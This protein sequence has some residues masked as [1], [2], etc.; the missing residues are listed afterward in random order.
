MPR[1]K[2]TEKRIKELPLPTDKDKIEYWDTEVT[3]L[4]VVA[5]KSGKKRYAFAYRFQSLQQN[6]HFGPYCKDYSLEAF[7]NDVKK[8]KVQ[9]TEHI[10]PFEIP[11]ESDSTPTVIEVCQKNLNRKVKIKKS[12]GKPLSAGTIRDY[13]RVNKII[14]SHHTGIG[15]LL[16]TQVTLEFAARF[17][18]A[19]LDKR[20][21]H[22]SIRARLVNVWK[23][24]V[25]GQLIA[26]RWDI[27]YN[28]WEL[29]PKM[30]TLPS[31]ETLPRHTDEEILM[32]LDYLKRAE[33][34]KLDIDV[35]QVWIDFMRF[36]IENGTRPTETLAIQYPW[37]NLEG[38]YVKHEFTKTGTKIIYLMDETVNRIRRSIDTRRSNFLFPSGHGGHRE[39]YSKEYGRMQRRIGTLPEPYGIRRWHAKKA[40]LALNGSSQELQ[41]L[42]SWKTE[43][44]ASRY[45]G[46]D[47]D[48]LEQEILQNRK[49]K[50]VVSEDIRKLIENQ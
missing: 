29:Q 49:R 11:D 7:R 21:E 45:S 8:W 28:P 18:E 17:L 14:E 5:R 33:L 38:G 41:K 37:I 34:G 48:I 15:E 40:R 26:G 42:M 9:L 31:P 24:D 46:N 23:E 4:C 3:Q 27:L 43:S 12:L 2:L 35:S 44:M 36:F 32:I 47:D 10:N 6:W 19:F 30:Y 50:G 13:E 20:R 25:I 16:V 1:L 39:N 22:D